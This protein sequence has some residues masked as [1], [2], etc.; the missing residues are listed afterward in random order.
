ME[1][2]MGA[3]EA[4]GKGHRQQKEIMGKGRGCG[5]EEREEEISR[6]SGKERAQAVERA[7]GKMPRLCKGGRGR[8]DAL[9]VDGNGRVSRL[10]WWERR[11]ELR[12]GKLK[13]QANG[14]VKK[15]RGEERV[16]GRERRGRRRSR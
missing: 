14:R 10:C 11:D 7:D 13:S 1:S 8:G 9:K 6:R 16:Q 15:G 4:K 5:E 2:K 12:M 3:V